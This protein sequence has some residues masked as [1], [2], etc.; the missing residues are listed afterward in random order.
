M[1]LVLA[2]ID[3]NTLLQKPDVL[4]MLVG[5]GTVAIII[6]G[7]TIA[8]QW[9]RVQQ[10]KY[11]AELKGRMIE[12]GFSADEIKTVLEAGVGRGRSGKAGCGE[13]MPQAR[14]RMDCCGPEPGT[15]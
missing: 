9:R 7:V 4:P 3:W 1:L 11:D 13:V 14:E 15:S 2:E 12:R 5:L 10:A 6:L 8:I